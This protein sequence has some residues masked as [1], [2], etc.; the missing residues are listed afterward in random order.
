M[1]THQ[2][3]EREYPVG[4]TPRTDNLRVG[5]EFKYKYWEDFAREL[6]RENAKLRE[7]LTCV[8]QN[9]VHFNDPAKMDCAYF[10]PAEVRLIRAA[11]A[12]GH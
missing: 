8:E 5:P 11:L 10:S 12:Q 6:E 3:G 4:D 1:A 7:A 9:I 2:T